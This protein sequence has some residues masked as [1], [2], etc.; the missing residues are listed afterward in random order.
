[1]NQPQRVM[2][3]AG[4]AGIGR[5]IAIAFASN[6]ARVHVCDVDEQA[7]EDV[8]RTAP[9]VMTAVV[10]VADERA[11]DRWFDSALDD[12]GGL[13]VL[14]N[15]AGIAGPTAYVEDIAP[16]A[17][18]ECLGDLS[19][20][21]LPVRAPCDPGDEGPERWIDHQPVVDGGPRRLRHAEP[22]RRLEVGRCRLHEVAGDRARTVRDPLQLHLSRCGARGPDPASH[23]CRGR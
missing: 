8:R 21:A 19:R 14:V 9:G 20:L 4:G 18:R 22:V 6:G 23:R 15:N 2:I 10:D 16:D 7:L 12:L 1:M 17:W 3:S 5:S 13:D 11:I